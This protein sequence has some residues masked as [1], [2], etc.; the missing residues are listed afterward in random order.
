MATEPS[1]KK[2]Y[3]LSFLSTALYS[4]RK[5]EPARSSA[6]TNYRRSR[7]RP[8]SPSSS[9]VISPTTP[10]RAT[11]PLSLASLQQEPIANPPALTVCQ[12]HGDSSALTPYLQEPDLPDT[13]TISQPEPDSPAFLCARRIACEYTCLPFSHLGLS[14]N[15]T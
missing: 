10:L 14:P 8:T 2:Q 3:H 9:V 7:C 4:G 1:E 11:T 12:E 13:L 6:G 15:C 5:E